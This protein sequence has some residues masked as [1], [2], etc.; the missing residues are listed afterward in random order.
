MP[1]TALS[2]TERGSWAFWARD[3]VRI[4]DYGYGFLQ[5][6]DRAAGN[7]AAVSV[8]YRYSTSDDPSESIL[9]TAS[10]WYEAARSDIRLRRKVERPVIE[11]AELTGKKVIADETDK[12][13]MSDTIMTSAVKDI[14][15][16]LEELPKQYRP[17][18]FP[19]GEAR[20]IML[21]MTAYGSK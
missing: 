16:E 19:G 8:N 1:D 21:R 10:E 17:D 4:M 20:R 11:A 13:E 6:A 12:S 5:G 2:R 14:D 7:G 3:T 9:N 15:S 18:K